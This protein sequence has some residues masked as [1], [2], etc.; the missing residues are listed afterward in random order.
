MICSCDP[1]PACLAPWQTCSAVAAGAIAVGSKAAAVLKAGGGLK[2][3][4]ALAVGGGAVAVA[5][6]SKEK[7]QQQPD[8][9]PKALTTA[10]P[11]PAKAPP[12]KAA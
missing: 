7:Q 3:L 2:G 11:E 10:A 9:Q 4:G 5:T 12:P 1:R 8:Q 6:S